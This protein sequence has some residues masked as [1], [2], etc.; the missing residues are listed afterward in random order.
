[1]EIA[2][3][4]AVIVLVAAVIT[5]ITIFFINKLNPRT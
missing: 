4:V 3:I 2:I 5:G 1:V